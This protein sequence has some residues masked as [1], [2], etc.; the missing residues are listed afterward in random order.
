[1][2]MADKLMYIPNQLVVEYFCWKVG[3]THKIAINLPR[4]SERLPYKGEP[5]LYRDTSVQ[6]DRQTQILFI[7]YEDIPYLF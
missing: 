4:T 2:T 1:M 3:E 6:T 7:L 5:Y